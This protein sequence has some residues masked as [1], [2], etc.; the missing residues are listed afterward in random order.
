MVLPVLDGVTVSHIE[1]G[2]VTRWQ[3]GHRGGSAWD[4]LGHGALLSLP[5]LVRLSEDSSTRTR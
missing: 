1:Q 4:G 5:K 2:A 3:S